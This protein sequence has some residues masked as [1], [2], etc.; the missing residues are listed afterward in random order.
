MF[1]TSKVRDRSIAGIRRRKRTCIRG[2]NQRDRNR[3]ATSKALSQS[4]TPALEA[5]LALEKEILKGGAGSQAKLK[6]NGIE[7][8][9]QKSSNSE[10]EEV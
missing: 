3:S 1:I 6:I 9:P 10:Y 2:I 5:F 8:R 7:E 4:M